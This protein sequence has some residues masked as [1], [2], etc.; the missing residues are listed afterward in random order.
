MNA[1]PITSWDGAE[2]VFTF[3]DN[4]AAIMIILG[5]SVVVTVGTIIASAIHENS[6]YVD[7]K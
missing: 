5:L 3:A 6:T 4:P 1:S 2:A 7:Y